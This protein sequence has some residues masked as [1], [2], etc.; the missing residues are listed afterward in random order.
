MPERID[1]HLKDVWAEFEGM[2]FQ[3]L[4]TIQT[5]A[6]AAE[7]GSLDGP[8][9]QS[10]LLEAHRLAGSLGTFGLSEGTRL[11]REIE[12]LLE[13]ETGGG[14][15]EAPRLTE[16]AAALTRELEDHRLKTD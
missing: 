13:R 6:Q 16:L 5:A 12:S 4:G 11:A 1:P 3:R 7:R 15:A 14:G 9:R 2:I 8:T 10:A